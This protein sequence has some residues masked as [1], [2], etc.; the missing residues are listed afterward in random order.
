MTPL[1]I[2]SFCSGVGGLDLAVEELTGG[3]VAWFAETDAHASTVLAAHW[4]GVPNHGDLTTF[5]WT[6][7]EPIDVLCAGFPCFAAGTIVHAEEGDRPIEEVREGDLVLTH[8]RRYRPVTALMRRESAETIEVRAGGVPPITTTA[9]HP[10]WARRRY[11]YGKGSERRFTAPEWVNAAEL[12]TDHFVA[13]PVGTTEPLPAPL[14]G[15]RLGVPLAYLVGRWLGDG[16]IINHPRVGRQNSRAM[17]AIICCAHHE[18]DDLARR[19]SEAGFHA[20]QAKERTVTKFHISSKQ[21]VMDLAPFGRGAENKRLPGWVYDLTHDEKA[22]LLNGWV[23]A[24]GHRVPKGWHATTVSRALA[25]GMARLCRE[26]E[27]FVPTVSMKVPA[28]TKVIEG[29]TVNQLPWYSVRFERPTRTPV[30]FIKDEMA[31]TQVRSVR[32]LAG[33]TTVFNIAVEQDESYTAN[34][35]TVHNCQP[36]SSAGKRKAMADERWLWDD[37]TRAVRDMAARPRWIF[38]ENVRG[39]LTAGGGLAMGHVL[40]DLAHLGYVGR[41]GLLPASAV[42]APHRRERVFVVAHLAATGCGGLEE[43]P[44][45]DGAEPSLH[46]RHL[47]RLGLQAASDACRLGLQRNRGTRAVVGS[48]GALEADGE[49]RQRGRNPFG[50]G[51]EA[52][53]A[54]RSERCDG[55]Q[56]DG[57]ARWAAAERGEAVD[58]A[59]LGPAPFGAF[60]PAIDRWE[61]VLGRPVP[62]PPTIGRSLNARLVEWMMGWPEGWVTDLVPNRHAL[63][64]C[65]NGV[66]P[67]Q[68]LA[69]YRSLTADWP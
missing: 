67:Q 12:T 52:A 21:L 28:P 23:D 29:R 7:A 24:D 25:V 14:F 49:E 13:L 8:L 36:V 6:T 60:Q 4:P 41:Y 44:P 15:E 11:R 63:R 55:R 56:G 38:L 17:K 32:P 3:E 51:G 5:D 62:W 27:G 19:I 18:A 61:R 69:A 31:W 46:E 64:L 53:A 26:V 58:L 43:Q 37:I 10:F 30:S 47:E 48:A 45:V 68:A 57:G 40:H 2:G 50:G 22:A 34:G 66:V 9:E 65:G 35:A 1:R 42:G 39:L 59:E 20:T 54:T 16:W 33:P